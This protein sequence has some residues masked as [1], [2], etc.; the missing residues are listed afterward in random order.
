MNV[1]IRLGRGVPMQRRKGKNRHVALALAGLLA[2]ASVM[3]FILAI[4]RIAADMSATTKFAIDEGPFSHW[5]VWIVIAVVLAVAA[6]RLNRY[7][8]EGEPEA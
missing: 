5:H 4:W 1:R 6:V 2:P 8:R 3:A 7:G